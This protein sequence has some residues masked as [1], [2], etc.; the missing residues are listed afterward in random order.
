MKQN[1]EKCLEMLL[2]HEG[3]YV[4]HPNDPGGETNLGVTRRV[5]E[6]WCMKNDIVQKDMK[7]LEVSDVDQIYKE[8]YWDVICGDTLPSGL[9]WVIF[10]FAVNAGPSRAVKTLQ[11]F[12]ATTVDGRMGPNTIAQTMLYPAGLKGVIETYT[13]QR[14]AFYKKL[15]TYSTFGKGWDRRCYETRKQAIDLLT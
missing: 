8:R 10:D 13:A 7:D 4:N 1:F 12:I 14:S 3:G 6:E 9:D 5:Y 15:K 2:H 11:Q